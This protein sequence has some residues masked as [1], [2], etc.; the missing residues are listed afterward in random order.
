MKIYGIIFLLLITPFFLSNRSRQNTKMPADVRDN[1]NGTV[2]WTKTSKSKGKRKWDDHGK[3]NVYRWDFFFEFKITV[4]F[5]NGK[6]TVVRSDKTSNRDT[7]SLIFVHPE[8][9]YMI[10]RR[11]KTITCEGSEVTDLSVEFSDD[12]KFYWISFFTPNCQQSLTYD[13]INNIQGNIHDQS[14][15]EQPGIQLTLPANFTGQPVGND[16]DQLSGT[17]EETIPAPND[18]GGGEIVTKATWN[19]TKGAGKQELI[20]SPSSE[21]A[22]YDSWIPEP[23][24]NE[25]MKGNELNIELHLQ[26]IDGSSPAVKAKFFELKLVNTSKQPGICI[27]APLSPSTPKPDLRFLPQE[28]ATLGPDGQTIK[29]PCEDGESGQAVIASYDGGGWTILNASAILTDGKTIKGVLVSDKSKKDIPIPKNN[30][31]GKIAEQWLEDN[32]RP[33]ETDDKETS[34]DNNNDG[35]GLSAYEEYRGVMSEGKFR[36][37]DPTIKELGVKF[38]KSELSIFADGFAKFENATGFKIIRFYDNEIP[39]NRRINQNGSYANIYPQFVLNLTMGALPGKKIAQSPGSPGIPTVV[40]S[41][42]LDQGK[43]HQAYQDDQ[44]EAR[45]MNA[46]LPYTEKEFLAH[47]VAHELGHGVNLAHH[48]SIDPNDIRLTVDTSQ[49]PPFGEPRYRVILHNGIES[50]YAVTIGGTL[51]VPQNAESGDLGC[52]M[53]ETT[54]CSWVEHMT[55]G[56]TFLYEVPIIPL[57]GHLCISPLG[58]GI[59]AGRKYF[60]DAAKGKCKAQLKLK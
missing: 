59:N 24:M 6:G 51:G 36:R 55:P 53:A 45:S 28:R 29:I 38:K 13:V 32:G 21:E 44:A 17:F 50:S 23:G 18:E 27:N 26:E 42:I 39:A 41:I 2:T 57:G 35:D 47:V 8:D 5:R 20:V 22:D 58:T 52:I 25:S 12:R 31:G 37:L 11:T 30:S 3:E 9:K 33:G 14:V 48:G 1:W 4:N 10:E 16:P 60:G 15:N 7:D 49:A 34:Q 43:I 56:V 19:L 40:T 54:L 46:T